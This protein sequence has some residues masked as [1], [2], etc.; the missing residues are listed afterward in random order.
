MRGPLLVVV[1]GL[2]VPSLAVAQ[3]SASQAQAT[4]QPPASPVPADTTD[5]AQGRKAPAG[6]TDPIIVTGRKPASKKYISAL[7]H[8][9]TPPSPSDSPL[10]RFQSAVCFGSVGLERSVLEMIGYRLAADAEQAGLKLAG[11]GCTPNIL[12]VFTDGVATGID[13]LV[14]RKWWIFGDRTPSEVRTIVGESGPVRAWSNSE[15]LSRDGA[16]IN[17]GGFLNVPIAS[18]LVSPTRKDM[19]ASIVLVERSAV[20]GKTSNQI[21]DYLA[22]RTLGGARPRASGP[23]ETILSLFDANASRVP[24]ELTAFDRGYLRGLY[25]GQANAFAWSTR[26][27]IVERVLKEQQADPPPPAEH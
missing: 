5:R 17:Q 10:A 21:A 15:V 12:V 22:M 13:T 19:L 1:A 18:R 26:G 6:S 24:S 3:Q 14:R 27:L 11:D 9:I 2:L 4:A 23:T 7:V 25:A 20:V 16:H 8:A